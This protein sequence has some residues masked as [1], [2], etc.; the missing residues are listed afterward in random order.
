MSADVLEGLEA[1]ARTE[2][3]RR[4]RSIVD[5]MLLWAPIAWL[6]LVVGAA[7]LADWLPLPSPNDQDLA[8]ILATPGSVHLFGGD[9]LGRDV[10]ARTI[11]ALRISLVAGVG[12]VAIGLVVGGL[13]GTLAG[14]FGGR[15][16]SVAMGAMDIVLAFPPLVLAIAITSGAGPALLKVILAIGVLFVPAFAR[17]ARA[18]TLVFGN[19][20]FVLAAHAMGMRHSRIILSEI[21]PN[22]VPPLL[23]Y[24]LLMVAV[25]IVAEASLSF[26]GLSV[27]PPAPSLGSMIAAEQR[28]VLDAPF[29]VF[30]PAAVLFLTVLTLNMAG[31]QVSRRLQVRE[32]LL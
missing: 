2:A 26:L 12:A 29:V 31:E 5:F 13:V 19:K 9:S 28:N 24:S 14:Y 7:A 20:E 30:F 21:L 3:R 27:P 4:R 6:V 32:Q 15:V 17:I 11:F 16:E 10:L 1:I 23:V 18:N 25:A 8:D 22:L